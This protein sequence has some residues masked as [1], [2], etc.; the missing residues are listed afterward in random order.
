MGVPCFSSRLEVCRAFATPTTRTLC[1][2]GR[3]SRCNVNVI[4]GRGSSVGQKA[5]NRRLRTET[6]LEIQRYRARTRMA[7]VQIFRIL[8]VP[9][10]KNTRRNQKHAL[11]FFVHVA[12]GD[13]LRSEVERFNFWSGQTFAWLNQFLRLRVRYEKRADIHEAFL[14]LGCALIWWRSFKAG[15]CGFATQRKTRERS[16]DPLPRQPAQRSARK[17]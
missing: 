15:R 16:L 7:V 13:A 14:S 3:R 10:N 17:K 1:D 6:A 4:G 12:M 5:A 8:Q 11:P 9:R 2:Q